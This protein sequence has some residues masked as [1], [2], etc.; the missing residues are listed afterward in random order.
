M[1]PELLSYLLQN[2]HRRHHSHLLQPLL[3][4]CQL[5][6]E[7]LPRR[8]SLH[9]ESSPVLPSAAVVSEP[10]NVTSDPLVEESQW[11]TK[12]TYHLQ[13]RYDE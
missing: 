6:P 8:Y 4:V 3:Q 13:F 2:P 10:Q 11:I 7:L 9:P 1:P 12:L 5:R